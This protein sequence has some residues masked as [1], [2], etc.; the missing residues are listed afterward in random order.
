MSYCV[1]C[2][3][4]KRFLNFTA[5]SVSVSIRRLTSLLPDHHHHF[6]LKRTLTI[7]DRIS[8]K[9]HHPLSQLTIDIKMTSLSKIALDASEVEKK[10]VSFISSGNADCA[11]C[12]A[13]SVKVDHKHFLIQSNVLIDPNEAPK[14]IV[15]K[16]GQ[17]NNASVS[18]MCSQ[19]TS[20]FYCTLECRQSHW[21]VHSAA[22]SASSSS[23]SSNIASSQADET[24]RQKVSPKFDSSIIKNTSSSTPIQHGDSNG[25]PAP[26]TP[27][28]V[29]PIRSQSV[30]QN[31]YNTCPEHDSMRTPER[32]YAPQAPRPR[33]DWNIPTSALRQSTPQPPHTNG[34]SMTDQTVPLST[35]PVQSISA[36]TDASSVPGQATPS[37]APPAAPLSTTPASTKTPEKEPV[38]STNSVTSPAKPVATP[39]VQVTTP[40]PAPTVK[41]EPVTPSVDRTVPV[42]PVSQSLSPPTQN[43]STPSQANVAASTAA[44]VPSEST[45]EAA[46][47]NVSGTSSTAQEFFEGIVS[48]AASPALDKVDKFKV[49]WK[50][51]LSSDIY[52]I[53]EI[54]PLADLIPKKCSEVRGDV[55]F[56]SIGPLAKATAGTFC[57]A[58]QAGD[59]ELYRAKI[60]EAKS[61]Q[62]KVFFIDFGNF[63][64]V[65]TSVLFPLPD[66]IHPSTCHALA[67]P[68]RGSD[69]VTQ[70]ALQEAYDQFTDINLRPL[71]KDANTYTV[72]C[73]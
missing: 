17:C 2:D 25:L 66:A 49:V 47:N 68:C 32:V 45:C 27:F 46:S 40:A 22:C 8:Y 3:T 69:E 24:D 9:D 5:R 48:H 72:S 12:T 43:T 10:V 60:I 44:T 53:S 50:S 4:V 29:E 42:A 57:L 36:T 63:D 54:S 61:G 7:V 38:A 64:V 56:G 55:E 16:C 59:P 41:V 14:P 73:V 30:Q 21:P 62:I 11:I 70:K 39:A 52:F 71:K 67:V 58:K 13:S 65:D 18:F 51:E 23:S 33:L 26:R 37:A 35:G 31:Q 28:P 6:T 34:S 19:C 1:H 20:C 15:I